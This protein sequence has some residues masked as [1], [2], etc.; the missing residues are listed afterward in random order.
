MAHDEQLE[1]RLHSAWEVFPA[2]VQ[3]HIQPKKMFGGIAFLYK[4]KMTVGIIKDELVV[5]VVPDRMEAILE[6][7]A[8]RL[9]D[10]TKRPMKEFIYVAPGGFKTEEALLGWMEL[11][12][13]HAKNKV[14]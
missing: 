11:G 6:H 12:L 4:G 3:E 2:A 5:R 1:K 7:P 9:M 8:V 13:E 14:D 10:F